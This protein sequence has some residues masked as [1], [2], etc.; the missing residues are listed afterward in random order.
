MSGLLAVV[1]SSGL[2][3]ACATG[4]PASP[5]A[6]HDAGIR[7]S[8]K[9]AP[10]CPVERVEVTPC[11]SPYSAE[12]VIVDRGGR[13]ITRVR[14]GPD[15]SFQVDLA[16][17]DYTVFP[18]PGDPFPVATSRDVTVVPGAFAEVEINYDSGIR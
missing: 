16:P 2:A 3:T 12:L 17:G 4:G 13:E 8:V 10:A 5:S 7:G 15:G 6:T 14:S 9:L 1:L 18:V 11:V